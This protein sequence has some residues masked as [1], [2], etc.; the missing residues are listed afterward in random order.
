MRRAATISAVILAGGSLLSGACGSAAAARAGAS[1]PKLTPSA[2]LRHAGLQDVAQT[3]VNRWQGSIS[4]RRPTEVN[5]VFVLGP[6]SSRAA[7]RRA[8]PTIGSADVA[9]D[10][11]WYLVVGA[12]TKQL[13]SPIAAASACLRTL[14]GPPKVTGTKVYKF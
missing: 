5:S 8:V 12:A 10:G 3:S 13:A 11:G 6:Y 4:H 7:V 1:R 14:P 9:A 2:C